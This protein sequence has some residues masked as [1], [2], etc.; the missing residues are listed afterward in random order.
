MDKK[1]KKIHAEQPDFEPSSAGLRGGRST[2]VPQVW[3][4][5]GEDDVDEHQDVGGRDGGHVPG[6]LTLE[7]VLVK[8]LN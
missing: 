7:L 6:G 3:L 4:T 2:T 1:D 5:Q 8:K